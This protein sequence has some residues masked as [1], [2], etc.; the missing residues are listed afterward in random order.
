MVTQGLLERLSKAVE[1]E[2]RP[3]T[4]VRATEAYRRVISGVLVKGPL[5]RH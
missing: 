5:F 4:D 2:V 3:I 1:A